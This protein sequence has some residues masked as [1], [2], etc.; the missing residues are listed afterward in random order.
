MILTLN[1]YCRKTFGKKLY[2]LSLDGGFTCPNRDGT[3]GTGGCIF[4][5]ASG[6]GDFTGRGSTLDGQ[7]EDAKKRIAAKNKN[8]GYIAYFQSFTN[9]YADVKTLRQ[10]FL[11]V[12][13]RDDI[14]V[15]SVATRPDCLEEEKIELLKELNSIKPV[16]V[17]LGLQTTKEESVK[18]I[19]RAYPNEIYEKAARELKEAGIYFITHIIIGLPGESVR[20][21]KNTLLFAL[22]NGTNGVK[23]QLLHVLDDAD[24]YEDYKKG[25]VSVLTLPQY[26]DVLKELLP[27]IP[28]D[29]AVHRLTGDGNKKHLV[30]PMWSADKKKVINEINKILAGL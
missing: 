27:L 18:Y 4:C 13:K 30:A 21:M 6:S 28:P 14:D 19:R 20:D 16:W 17:E 15:L 25:K 1:D 10:R 12:I 22:D 29:V 11:P 26:S 5:S 2:K 9:T 23:L 24:I 8:G 3:L 7:I